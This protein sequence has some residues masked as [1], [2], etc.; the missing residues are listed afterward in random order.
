MAQ[1]K[2][3]YDLA[4]GEKL[5]INDL[6][7]TYQL[8]FIEQFKDVAEFTQASWNLST[9]FFKEIGGIRKLS[10]KQKASILC[11]G[12]SQRLLRA[13]YLLTER[14][15]WIEAI[16]L[17]RTQYELQLLFF[18]IFQDESDKRAKK[19][20]SAKNPKERWPVKEMQKVFG[21]LE[22]STAKLYESLSLNPHN[23]FLSFSPFIAFE[24][25]NFLFQQG[26]L[27]GDENNKR[28]INSLGHM[29][30]ANA[31]FCEIAKPYFSISEKWDKE[32]AKLQ[33]LPYYLEIAKRAEKILN[34]SQN[35]LDNIV[36]FVDSLY[37]KVE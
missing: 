6:E 30:N 31:S 14:G 1:F 34:Q 18:Y 5:E 28:A 8:N 24:E 33:A 9:L 19:W 23:H 27:G 2:T 13:A 22:D 16:P 10:P 25:D 7:S 32:H 17:M 20:L 29:A 4:N 3:N 15:L 21:D 26:P 12:K 36:G 37:P 35:N 11:I